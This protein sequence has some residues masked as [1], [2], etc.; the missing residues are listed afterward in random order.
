MSD[1]SVLKELLI[2]LSA[3]IPIVFLFQKLRLPAVVGFLLAGVIMG[4]D[5]LGLIRNVNQVETLAEIGVVLLLFTIGLEF[6]LGQ[7]LSVQRT[8]IWAGILQ[9]L[10]TTLVILVVSLLLG[11][12]PQVGIFYGFLVSLSSTAIVLKIYNDRG[13]VDALQGRLATGILLFQDLCIVPMMLL[14]PVLGQSG[15]VSFPLIGW[16]LIKAVLV[17]LLIVLT[18]RTL[19]PRLLHQIALLRNRELFILFVIFVCLGTAWLTSESGLSL[20]LGAFIAGLVISESEFRHQIVAD[21]LPLKDCFSGIF[22]ISIGM[23]LDLDFLVHNSFPALLNLILIV[24]IK[25]LVVFLV[26][27]WLYRSLR[28]GVVLALSLAQ[29]GE[30]SFILAKAGGGYGLLIATGEQSFLAAS[31]LSM[32][33]T[34]FLI[35]WVHGLAFGLETMVL[36]LSG[37]QSPEEGKG[38][39]SSITGHVIVVGYGLNGQNLTRVLKEVG[40]P[41][42]ILEM[43]PDLVSQARAEG[44]PISFGDG[45]RPDVLQM[46]GLKQARILVI[47]ISDPIATA[48]VVSQARRLRPDLYLIVRTRYVAEIDHL[49]RLGASQVIPEEFE[50]SVE[51]FARVLQEYHIPRNVISLQVDLIRKEHYGTLRGL[52]LQG[53]RLDELSQFLAGTTTDTA[54]ILEGS[55]AVGKNLEELQLR[56]RSGVTV[57]AAVRNGT[58][59]HNPGPDFRLEAGDVLVLLGSHKELDQAIQVLSP[60]SQTDE[61]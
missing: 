55:P 52:H 20:A 36:G 9:I 50:T 21:I 12:A 35:Q 38:R 25:S 37:R 46:M 3:I 1:I 32:I 45:T 8:V 22:F 2:V 60:L 53:K 54:L 27:C 42:G 29:I 28:L 58:S 61:S 49:Y 57:I 51:I 7:L 14:V 10:L 24:G 43:D 13:E 47:A 59:T 11:Y 17:L 5:G 31:I 41:Y 26:F 23:L 15:R 56:S 33:A 30:F 16:A 6:S 44:E 39:E 40:I 4:P 48:H 34:P 19:L 18:A